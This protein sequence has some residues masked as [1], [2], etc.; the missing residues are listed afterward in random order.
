MRKW[1][2]SLLFSIVAI[3]AS[4]GN[5]NQIKSFDELMTYLKQGNE[6]HVVL[7][8]AKCQLISDNE[9]VDNVPNAIGGMT[10]DVWEY[11]APMAIRNEKAF[12]VSSTSKL[13]QNPKGE[14]FVYNY[15]KIRFYDDNTVKI[16]AEYLDANSIEVEMTENFFGKIDNGKNNE[17]IYIYAD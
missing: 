3:S 16:T 13:I 4:A 2:I 15:V 6:V 11:F 9:I 1:M 10:L 5:N 8:Y 17:G 14:G 7:H 12:V